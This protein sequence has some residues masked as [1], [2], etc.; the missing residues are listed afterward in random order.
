[1]CIC[2]HLCGRVGVCGYAGRWVGVWVSRWVSRIARSLVEHDP[3]VSTA[4]VLV[5]AFRCS[6]L[7]LR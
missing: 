6:S 2:G 3:R 7:L 4:F 5:P 1:M